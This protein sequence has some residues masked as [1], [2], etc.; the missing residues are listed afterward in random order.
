MLI[1]FQ[2]FNQ[3]ISRYLISTKD[4]K[5]SFKATMCSFRSSLF[6]IASSTQ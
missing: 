4:S 6:K 5:S 3:D 2:I 1:K